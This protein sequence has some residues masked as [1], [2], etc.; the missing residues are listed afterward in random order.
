MNRKQDIMR[1]ASLYAGLFLTLSANA[2]TLAQPTNVA[3]RP[4]V[5]TATAATAATTA[6]AAP[7]PVSAA[8][9]ETVRALLIPP[10]ETTL[11]SPVVGTIKAINA[12][13][14]SSFSKGQTL[15]EFECDEPKARL[16]MA[17]A[18]LTG[19]VEQHEA[20]LRMQGLEQASEVEVALA[21]SAVAKARAQAALNQAQIA[22]CTVTAPWA[23]RVSRLTGRSFMSVTPGQPLL[24]IVRA[25][26]LKLK[27]NAPSRWVAQ[28]QPGK[29]MQV[30]VDET[31]KTYPARIARVNSRVDAASQTVELEA[32][33][34][35]SFAELLP[36]MSGVATI[37]GLR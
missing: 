5:G 28:I 21:A 37:N 2:Q 6:A 31:G 1:A 13:L 34:N 36:G 33:M 3:Y 32:Q 4:S 25:G 16:A 29:V 8:S 35:A 23:G 12:V 17:Q 15:I 9:A 14:G 20:K 24:D 10:A 18:E 19:A 30:T 11:S 22:Q 7:A 27:L 26:P